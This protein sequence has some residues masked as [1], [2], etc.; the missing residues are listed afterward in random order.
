M[1]IRSEKQQKAARKKGKMLS[2]T[3]ELGD[4]V[5]I[6]N[7]ATRRW[8]K[9]G[10]IKE[11]RTADN[12]Q[13]VS[14]II[15]LPNGRETIRH[16][17]H[18]RHNINR[19]THITETKVRFDLKS[20]KKEEDRKKSETKRSVQPLKLHKSKSADSWEIVSNQNKDSEIGM[21]TRTRSKVTTDK[22]ELSLKSALKK[23]TL[24]N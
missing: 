23:R 1:R 10:V 19:Y 13:E 11:V 16:R 3:F 17:S 18:L 9:S 2:D 20:D 7:M 15:S 21:A 14:F 8:D 4:D 24:E 12:G 22:S 5:R 6:Q